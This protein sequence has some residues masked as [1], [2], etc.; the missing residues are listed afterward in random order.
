MGSRNPLIVLDLVYDL[1]FKVNL[2][3][4]GDFFE[5]YGISPNLFKLQLWTALDTYRKVGSM[6][7][8]VISVMTYDL[9]FKVNLKVNGIIH[10]KHAILS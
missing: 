9:P 7:P 3:V 5:N 4:K 1:S 2:K 8:C 6:N 10:E